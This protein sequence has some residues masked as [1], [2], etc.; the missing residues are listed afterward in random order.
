MIILVSGAPGTG[1]TAFAVKLTTESEYYPDSVVVFN[2]RDWKGAG[3][4][5]A[6]PDSPVLYEKPRTVYL[7]DEA[8]T[9]WPS[10]V[11]GRPQPPIV[12]HLA[13]HRHISQDWI[14]TV[15]HPGQLDIGIRRLVGRHIHLTRTP[16]GVRFS[17]AGECREDLKFSRDESR[18]YDFPV[19][20]LE[21]YKSDE[22]VTIHQK[23]GLKLPKRL[24][25]LGG[26]AVVLFSSI[27]YFYNKSSIFG[28]E[29]KKPIQA[30]QTPKM[31]EQGAVESSETLP[32][33]KAPG[34]VYYLPKDTAFPEIAR[35][36]RLPVSCIASKLVCKCYDQSAQLIEGFP[37]NRCRAIV[38]GKNALAT[39]YPK[40]QQVVKAP[41][42]QGEPPAREGG[43]NSSPL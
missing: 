30:L 9:F 42:M 10:R 29:E 41:D 12:E 27:V 43:G 31:F 20:S 40:S 24:M 16:L 32:L 8:Q 4:Y 15:Q 1:K 18:K 5:H 21:L 14:L 25:F 26:L 23:K 17:E 36:P 34:V 28:G 2:V 6:S 13:K 11:A 33:D 39:L 3:E 35:A 7:V 19:E 38:A 37:E 22:G